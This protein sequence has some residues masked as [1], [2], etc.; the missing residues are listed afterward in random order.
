MEDSV[1]SWFLTLHENTYISGHWPSVLGLHCRPCFHSICIIVSCPPYSVKVTVCKLLY[2][3]LYKYAVNIIITPLPMICEKVENI[4]VSR[5]HFKY[6][7]LTGFLYKTMH[8]SG[9]I[10]HHHLLTIVVS[11][12]VGGHVCKH[13]YVST[14]HLCYWISMA[15]IISSFTKVRR[16]TT[17]P[18]FHWF[19]CKAWQPIRSKLYT[20]TPF[21][22]MFHKY[23]IL[24]FFS[25][26]FCI[27]WTGVNSWWT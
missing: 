8:I 4:A 6:A 18:D 25:V 3:I 2:E 13:L 7:E 24:S 5:M 11:Y 23:L 16:W 21:T 17:L 12:A 14:L 27:C 9:P 19:S 15:W 20:F 10:L 1:C 26:R 22:F